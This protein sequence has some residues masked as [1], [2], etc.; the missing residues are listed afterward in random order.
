MRTIQTFVLT[1]LIDSEESG[2]LRGSL[3]PI[4]NEAEYPF[5]DARSLMV[6]LEQLI[7]RPLESRPTDCDL[8]ADRFHTA[9]ADGDQTL[10]SPGPCDD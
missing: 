6:L 3:H 8:P 10:G 9:P 5:A 4:A 7:V 1:L 2:A